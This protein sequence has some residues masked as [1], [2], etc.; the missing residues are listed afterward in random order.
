MLCKYLH[1]NFENLIQILA[2]VAEIGLQN[3]SSRGLFL[4]VDLVRLNDIF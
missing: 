1:T 4:L 2:T 3:L